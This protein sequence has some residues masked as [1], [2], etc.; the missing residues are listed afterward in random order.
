ML[1]TRCLNFQLTECLS[2]VHSEN[3]TGAKELII[4][5]TNIPNISQKV[6]P[7]NSDRSLNLSLYASLTH[8]HD[9]PRILDKQLK[10]SYSDSLNN[11]PFLN[12]PISL[13]DYML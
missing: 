1:V 13:E 8:T 10:G 9:I 3:K 4:L 6:G 5:Q 2:W 12:S 11:V 7:S